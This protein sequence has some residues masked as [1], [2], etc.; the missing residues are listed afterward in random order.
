M[1]IG[2]TVIESSCSADT[3][4]NDSAIL[5]FVYEIALS[6]MK[7]KNHHSHDSILVPIIF[8][9]SVKQFVITY[10]N[11]IALSDSIVDYR[12]FNDSKLEWGTISLTLDS[13]FNCITQ[14]NDSTLI[15]NDTLAGYIDSLGLNLIME[16]ENKFALVDTNNR[17]NVYGDFNFFYNISCI[18]KIELNLLVA[19]I[20]P[21]YT[22]RSGTFR[23]NKL[24]LNF[25]DVNYCGSNAY[26]H[27][28]EYAVTSNCKIEILDISTSTF[29]ILKNV[30]INIYPNPFDNRIYFKTKEQIK[31]VNLFGIDGSNFKK[32]INIASNNIETQNLT[33]GVY[34]IEIECNNGKLYREKLIKK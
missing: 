9:D 26:S 29:D 27:K 6:E 18:Q 14:Q 34:I 19:D 11:A 15:L 30:D 13:S 17:I 8:L 33:T 10:H 28:W 31:S 16:S 24:Y 3:I 21:C 12:N 22:W 32:N 20:G 7:N 23:E 25:S 4:E 1:G 2:Q 5:D